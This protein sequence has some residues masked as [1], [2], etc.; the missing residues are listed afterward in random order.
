[1]TRK[2]YEAIANAIRTA[3]GAA[4]TQYGRD[5]QVDEVIRLIGDAMQA[6]NP[7]FSRTKFKDACIPSGMFDQAGA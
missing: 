3:R 5:A 1:M 4:F 2:D 7:R 6:D